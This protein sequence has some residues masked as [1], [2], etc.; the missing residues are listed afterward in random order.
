MS[1][2]VIFR[3]GGRVE[4]RRAETL[5]AALDA[6]E[7][8]TR[9]AAAGPPA[10]PVDLRRRRWEP[11]DQV[12]AR[13][14]LRGPQRWRPDV[15]AGIDVRGDGSAVAWTGAPR[16]EAIDPREAEDAWTAL[17]RVVAAQSAS[18]EP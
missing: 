6:L 16:R 3:P 11:G 12:A 18:V 7:A 13:A 10:A 14:E 5:E 4:R 17:R 15:R 8:L 9:A 2:Q 1:W